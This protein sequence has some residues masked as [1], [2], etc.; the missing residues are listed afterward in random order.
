MG[1]PRYFFSSLVPKEEQSW[2]RENPHPT[3]LTQ[4]ERR[5]IYSN[6]QSAE[7][8]ELPV[9]SWVPFPDLLNGWKTRPNQK[10]SSRGLSPL[11]PGILFPPENLNI[12]HGYP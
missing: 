11:P 10:S 7:V 5:V 9:L 3:A 2:N 1:L 8:I 4:R 6:S 12:L